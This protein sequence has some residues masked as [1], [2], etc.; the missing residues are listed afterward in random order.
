MTNRTTTGSR[1]TTLRPLL[2]MSLLATVACGRFDARRQLKAGNSEYAEGKYANAIGAFTKVVDNFPKAQAEVEA[3]MFKNGQAF[4]AI[5][6]CEDARV[7]FQELT[8]R[9][10]KTSL[11]AEANEQVKEITQKLKNKTV[12]Q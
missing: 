8:K 7:Y 11:K 10:P 3:A 4:F 5:K 9:Y 2:A 12:C 1:H 6:R